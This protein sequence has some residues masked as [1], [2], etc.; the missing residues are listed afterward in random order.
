MVNAMTDEV[1][2]V[3]CDSQDPVGQSKN[4]CSACVQMMSK[5]FKGEFTDRE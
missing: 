1:A 2:S 3:N 4:P 5:G